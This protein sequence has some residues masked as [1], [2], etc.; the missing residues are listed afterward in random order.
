MPDTNVNTDAHY[1]T[2][3]KVVRKD[4]PVITPPTNIPGTKLFSDKDANLRLNSINS[5]IYQG[6]KSKIKQ[7]SD[8]AKEINNKINKEKS[9]KNFNKILFIKIFAAISLITAAVA[10]RGKIKNFLSRIFVKI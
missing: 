2:E 7:H 10:F 9:N 6:T 4:L 5:D 3:M 1:T 8:N